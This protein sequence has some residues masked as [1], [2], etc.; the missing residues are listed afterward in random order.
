MSKKEK[1]L[2]WPSQSLE[3]PTLQR[4]VGQIFF[5]AMRETDEVIEKM[6]TSSYCH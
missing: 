5:T 3:L 2:Q 1:N 4:R 6:V